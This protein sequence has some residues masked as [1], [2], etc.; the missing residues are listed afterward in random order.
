MDLSIIIVNY[1]VKY[2]LEHCLLSV[3]EAV[4]D[5]NAEIWVVDNHSVDNSMEM[6]RSKFPEVKC[7]EN[8]ENL[9][10]SKANNQAIKLSKGKYVLLLNPDT[11]VE[12][13]TFKKVIEFM[14][15]NADAGGLGVYMIDGKGNF[16]PESKRGLPKPSVAFYKIFGLSKLFPK[17]KIFG[18][19]HLTYLNKNEIHQVDVLSGA[20]MLMRKDVLDQVGLLD[21]DYFMYG[22]DIDLSYR[23][24][25][26]GYKNYYFPKTKIIHYK[27]ESTKKSSINYVFVFYRAMV[28]FAKKHFSHKNARLFSLLINMAI[29]LRAFLA[30]F[31]RFTKKIILPLSDG[32]LLY[33]GLILIK[34]YWEAQTI[35]HSVM[36]YPWQLTVVIFPAYCLV[37]LIAIKQMGGYDKPVNN[38]KIVQGVFVGTLSILVI[39]ALLSEHYRFSRAI[40]LLGSFWSVIVLTIYRFLLRILNVNNEI[41]SFEKK[42]RFAIVGSFDEAQRVNNMLMQ[43][44]SN[45]SFVG[46]VSI[47]NSE[48]NKNNDNYIGN[49]DSIVDIIDIF[50]IDEIIFCAKDLNS[51]KIIHYMSI[52]PDKK[53]DFK[54]APPESLFVIGSNSIDTTGELYT[55]NINAISKIANRRYKRFFDIA[56]S[57]FLFIFSPI[58]FMWVEKKC[59][60]FKNIFKVAFGLKTW[61]GYHGDKFNSELPI[62]KNGITSFVLTIKNKNVDDNTSFKLNALYAR[63]YK[64]FN[65]VLII[66]KT[67]KFL[68]S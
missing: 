58:I 44:N 25:K 24:T 4:K 49:I 41:I 33:I 37:W 20:F 7:I 65:D 48:S 3:R 29:Y 26:G 18:K 55:I 5:I 31:A 35:F 19:Y 56:F 51:E 60:F 23:I 9:G 52:L 62:L 8:K 59:N 42:S 50:Q 13:D 47:E 43:I 63:D 12:N 39:Y 32:L 30:I 68:G 66:W 28:I 27:G 10:F 46:F 57:F 15:L 40:I 6:V 38:Y 64:V 45:I 17:S 14:E 34:N 11:V 53:V 21:E 1:N 36:Q 54:I 2:F 22:E 16:L 61:V 67:F